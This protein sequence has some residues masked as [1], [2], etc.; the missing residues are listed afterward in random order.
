[1]E[2]QIS[3]HSEQITHKFHHFTLISSSLHMHFGNEHLLLFNKAPLS[4]LSRTKETDTTVKEN[5]LKM[6]KTNNSLHGEFER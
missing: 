1:M 5:K 4:Q 6:L 3:S 2:I